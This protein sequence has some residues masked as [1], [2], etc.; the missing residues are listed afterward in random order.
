MRGLEEQIASISGDP[1]CPKGYEAVTLHS[2]VS[3]ETYRD[4]YFVPEGRSRQP[5]FGDE[6]RDEFFRQAPDG[7]EY[8]FWVL[9]RSRFNAARRERGFAILEQRRRELSR[10]S[11]NMALRLS[12]R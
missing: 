9:P 7:S 3:D 12:I 10:Q 11:G 1:K 5:G 8:T 2:L 6:I 4:I